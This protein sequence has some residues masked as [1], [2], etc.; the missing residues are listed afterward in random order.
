M[1][2]VTCP[3]CGERG[4]IPSN[5]IGSRIK[6]KKCGLSFTVAAPVAKAGAAAAAT[7]TGPSAVAEAHEGIEVEGLDAAHWAIPSDTGFALKAEP[8]AEHGKSA[9]AHAAFVPDAPAAGG[10][11]EY[12]IVTSKDKIFDNRFD[13]ARLEEALNLFARQGWVVRAFSTPHVKGFSGAL[14]E[15]IVVLLERELAHA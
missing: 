11:R 7:P 9:E 10:P 4:K 1:P 3:T 12:K 15:T 14:E 13:L 2:S 6:C 5:L 8:A